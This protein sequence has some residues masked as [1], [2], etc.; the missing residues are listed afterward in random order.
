MCDVSYLNAD[1]LNRCIGFACRDAAA[2]PSSPFWLVGCC[3]Q[4]FLLISRFQMIYPLK[5]NASPPVSIATARD[6][7]SAVSCNLLFIHYLWEESLQRP[8]LCSGPRW[9]CKFSSERWY[10]LIC[11]TPVGL[12][13]I[14]LPTISRNDSSPR[15][16]DKTLSSRDTD[17]VLLGA[18]FADIERILRQKAEFRLWM[19]RMIT[20][21][22]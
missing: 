15:W 19:K 10:L 7:L 6:N 20:F 16:D 22:N 12:C 21:P 2:L 8:V 5:W 3:V 4:F 17:D 11:P 14:R 9:G 1:V 13:R 18:V